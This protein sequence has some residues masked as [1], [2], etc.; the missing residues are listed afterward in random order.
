MSEAPASV[1]GRGWD[2][3]ESS[4]TRIEGEKGKILKIEG[5]WRIDEKGSQERGKLRQG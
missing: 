5:T 4:S 1:G 3:G 2:I